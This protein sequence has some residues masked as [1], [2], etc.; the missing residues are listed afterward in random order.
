MEHS[1][2][3]EGDRPCQTLTAWLDGS[4]AAKA[5]LDIAHLGQCLSLYSCID[6]GLY[7]SN[8]DTEENRPRGI[9]FHK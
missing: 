7:C 6:G 3:E 5:W 8:R 4:F 1:A 2:K 9:T